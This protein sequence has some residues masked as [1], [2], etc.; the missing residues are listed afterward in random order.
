MH[1]WTRLP[2][3]CDGNRTRWLTV[4]CRRVLQQ[5]HPEIFAPAYTKRTFTSAAATR[6]TQRRH[7]LPCFDLMSSSRMRATC[8]VL[9]C[10]IDLSPRRKRRWVGCTWPVSMYTSGHRLAAASSRRWEWNA[11]SLSAAVN[12]RS[13]SSRSSSDLQLLLCMMQREAE[14]F[15]H[16]LSVDQQGNSRDYSPIK[17]QHVATPTS[18]IPWWKEKKSLPTTSPDTFTV[19]CSPVILV[20]ST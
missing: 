16:R 15:Y 18:I 1:A 20:V 8:W 4:R 7:P 2:V 11:L 19:C 3:R 17:P 9:F 13:L 10:H 5:V 14:Y 6:L 12:E